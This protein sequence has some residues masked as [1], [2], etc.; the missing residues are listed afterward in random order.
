MSFTILICAEVKSR[1]ARNN[2]YFVTKDMK[3][4]CEQKLSEMG[5]EDWVL[6][7]RQIK[8]NRRRVS[9]RES[10]IGSFIIRF[11]DNEDNDSE[12]EENTNDSFNSVD[13]E[14]GIKEF[15]NWCL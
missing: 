3:D 8:K 13:E 10:I 9:W 6:K 2:M 12:D 1:I 4:M 7:H 14:S 11:S 5:Q 15:Q